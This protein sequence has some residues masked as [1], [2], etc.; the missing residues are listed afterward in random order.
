MTQRPLTIGTAGHIDHGK[1]ALVGALT[2][3]QTDRLP[4]ERRRGISIELG[5]AQLEIGERSLSIVDVPGHERF[6][7]TMIAGATGVDIFLMV[8]DAHEG[9]KPQTEEHLLILRSLGI[10]AGVCA[11][12]KCDLAEPSRLDQ[13]RSEAADLLPGTPIIPT[14]AKT[15]VGIEELK[16]AL[17]DVA[18]RLDREEQTESGADRAAVLHIDR[19]FSLK[20]H[21]TIVTGTSTSGSFR[22][23][24]SAALLPG[25]QPVRLRSIQVHDREV[26]LAEPHQRVALNLAG[27]GRDE[28]NRGDVI[29]D[30]AEEVIPTYRFDASIWP[31]EVARELNGERVNI[32]HGTRETPAR[33]IHLDDEGLAQLRLEQPLLTRP[34]DRFVVRR[35]SS[36]ET[37]G[38]GKILDDMARRHGPGK[39]TDW[40]RTIRDDGPDEALRF[41]VSQGVRIPPEPESWRS[42][43]AMRAAYFRHPGTE[44]ESALTRHVG[45]GEK[46]EL[47]EPEPTSQVDEISA[48][49]V[50]PNPPMGS[51]E[52]K[53][54]DLL[55][56]DGHKPRPLP[57]LAENLDLTVDEAVDLLDALAD[58]TRVTKVS[59]GV[60]FHGESMAASE[61]T[62]IQMA[63]DNGSISIAEL[64]D[65]LGTGRKHAQAILEYCD[66]KKITYRRD[67][68]RY[69]RQAI[70]R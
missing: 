59:P 64:R 8:V 2:G 9:I 40:L 66:G 32:H 51:R 56:A 48:P 38:G 23:G 54:L 47:G 6:V 49:I 52:L 46:S 61:A 22:Q 19:V 44:W 27:I 11:L 70:R 7:R 53:A 43:P 5:Y 31:P 68:R 20:G 16:N 41:R 55:A 50:V 17:A 37:V 45:T 15:G 14:S 67:D 36:H 26:E 13:V 57:T 4:E 1:S 30:Q 69:L 12:T 21:G 34:G 24:Q 58:G 35:I 28:V 60:Y 33:L 3:K 10:P 42:D 25:S 65:E 29:T 39:T 18:N 63:A 62:V